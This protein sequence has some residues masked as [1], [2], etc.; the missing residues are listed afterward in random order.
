MTAERAGRLA[1]LLAMPLGMFVRIGEPLVVSCPATRT[2]YLVPDLDWAEALLTAGAHPRNLV[3][4][5]SEFEGSRASMG[6][7]M[8]RH[9]RGQ[10]IGWVG[11]ELLD[12]LTARGLR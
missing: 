1:E 10:V 7:L 3:V 2:D 5:S 8:R 6:A 4:A 11:R 9:M 12:E